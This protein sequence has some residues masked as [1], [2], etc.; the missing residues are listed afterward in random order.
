LKKDNDPPG[1]KGIPGNGKYY[2]QLEGFGYT[3]LMDM[4]AIKKVLE[5]KKKY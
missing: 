5:N 1:T 4:S 3:I 2:Q